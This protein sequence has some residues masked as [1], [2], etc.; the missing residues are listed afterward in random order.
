MSL[1]KKVCVKVLNI[2]YKNSALEL[3][4]QSAMGADYEWCFMVLE[5]WD[6][7]QA[8]PGP[9][10][11]LGHNVLTR[12]QAFITYGKA[13]GKGTTFCEGIG[14]EGFEAFLVESAGD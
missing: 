2:K 8:A 14:A 4:C 11:A 1:N 13:P 5:H 6:T 12:R 10:T 7:L 3:G 9:H